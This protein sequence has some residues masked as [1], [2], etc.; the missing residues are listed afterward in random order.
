MI[1]GFASL[2]RSIRPVGY[3]LLLIWLVTLPAVGYSQ[4]PRSMTQADVER[5][6]QQVSNWGRWG[7]EDQLGTLNLITAAKRQQAAKLVRAGISVSLARTVE[8]TVTPDNPSPFQQTMLKTGNEPDNQWAVDN[9]SVSYHGFAHTHIDSLCH[10]IYKG[11]MY[12]GFSV[13]EITERGTQ[14]LS[15]HNLKDGIFTRGILIDIPRLRGVAYLEAGDAIY[16]EELTAWEN[17]AGI[18]VSSG[19]VVFF[20]TGRWARRAAKGPW[21]VQDEGVA[22][23][24]ASCAKWIRERDVAMVGSDAA[25]DVLPS[26]IPGVTHPIHLLTLNA[27]GVHIFDNCDLEAVATTC[28]RLKRW[29]FLLNAAPIPVQGGTG[30]P[31]NPIA[32]F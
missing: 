21:S 24:H 20:R 17:R 29:E 31:L 19:D 23:L 15:I 11:K 5:L 18:K 9:Y 7:K 27:M 12:N 16:P 6:F 2:P 14:Q 3:R 26:G 4:A 8:E 25:M 22:G 1:A 10:L 13:Q 32:T 30:S 28:A